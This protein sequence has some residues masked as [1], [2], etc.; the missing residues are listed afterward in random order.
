MMI[1]SICPTLFSNTMS[2]YLRCAW[3]DQRLNDLLLSRVNSPR[4]SRWIENYARSGGS[5][6]W[7]IIRPSPTSWR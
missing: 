6:A 2:G 7:L 5:D 3:A 4:M 1:F